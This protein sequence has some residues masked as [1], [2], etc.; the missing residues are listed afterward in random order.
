M[1]PPLLWFPTRADALRHR[2]ITRFDP[3][4]WT[5]NFP[6]PMMA[7]V[8]TPGGDALTVDLV[9]YR[10]EDLAG[11]IWESE[12][13]FDHPLL[14]YET[15]RDYRGVKLT[16]RWQ[17]TGITPLDAVWGPTMTVEGRDQ[18]GNPRVWYVRLWNYAG[19]TGEDAVITLDFDDLAGGFI[20]PDQADP[21]WA[22]DVDRLFIS[23]VPPGYD[24]GVSSGPLTDVFGQPAPV[25]G[26]VR[27]TDMR[28]TGPHAELELADTHAGPQALR[29][30]NGYDDVFNV[31]PERI[32][33]NM[34][35][36]GFRDLAVHYVGMSHYYR[37]A[38]NA[39]E[40]RFR[41]D[42]GAPVLNAA[43]EAWH[44]DYFARLARLGV[45][46]VL[47]VSFELL[48]QDAPWEWAQRAFD[49]SQALTGWVPPSTLI[50]P[51]NAE[52]LQYLKDVFSAFG[53]LM[54]AAGLPPVFQIGEPWWWVPE[55]GARVPHFY[56]AA[57]TALWTAETGLPVPPKHQSATETPASDQQ[58]Y[59]DWLGGKLGA[60]TLELRDHLKAR[61]PG[62][63][64]TVLFFT[65]QVLDETAPMLETV[66]F[67][68]AQWAAP[69]FA[70][71]QIE[72]YSHVI[73]GAWGRHRAALDR[74]T[75]DLG[76][77]A[78]DTHFFSGFVL[79]AD[80]RAV[81]RNMATALADARARGFGERVI[82]AYPQVVRDGAFLF[83]EDLEDGMQGFHDVVFPERIGFGSSGG[84]RYRTE[85]VETASGHERRNQ[86]WAAGRAE[87]DIST[88]LRSEADLIELLA[89]FRARQGRAF[90][91]RFRDWMDDSSAASPD[92]PVTPTDQVIGTGDGSTVTFALTK[93]YGTPPDA[94]VRRI[95]RPVAGSV[96]VAIDGVEQTSGFA[97]DAARGLLT[98][99]AAPP[100]GSTITAGFRFHV[101]VRF[102]DDRLNISLEAF[103]A[104]AIPAIRLVEIPDD[105]A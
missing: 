85:V 79:N 97:V 82:W 74:V 63:E 15:R 93:T 16:F 86:L 47:S 48:A 87:Y 77:A 52:A 95:T 88:G 71:F 30:A 102:A 62:A 89:F 92:D 64:V 81:W 70:F 21:V 8:T 49:G 61:H 12:D 10:K 46:L 103:R 90:G 27:I 53:D 39:G 78:A 29:I 37:L 38:W 76:Y 3:A 33:R 25:T 104:G 36:L 99:D 20:L 5:V 40:G 44:A 50:A 73:A 2:H 57:T 14:A 24:G 68:K 23:L 65:P 31:T 54:T 72:D 7:A 42:P 6:R 28:V 11:L 69:A 96:R 60:A 45:K 9:F 58:A 100:P 59:L 51:T 67:P 19:G 1:R 35:Q 75:A 26:R 55:T 41:I 105:A 17:S 66:N 94:E 91:F 13:R 4:F 34:R 56:D 80:D 84:P 98:F 83:E 22:G 43:A 32:I 18:N 101:P